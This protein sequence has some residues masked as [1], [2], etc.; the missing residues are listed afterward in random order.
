MAI[1]DAVA[2]QF[3]R[4]WEIF[5]AAVG[6]FPAEE[7]RVGDDDYRV[8]A[9]LAYHLIEAAEFYARARPEGGESLWRGLPDWEAA[10][11]H[12]FPTQPQIV[13]YVDQVQPFVEGWL[14]KA[15]DDDML[16]DNAFPWTE[17]TVL[18]RA[19]YLLRHTQHHVAEL[20]LE[21]RRRGLSRAEWR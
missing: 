8:P 15:G 20:N 14:R 1:G 6:N 12:E 4:A 10:R 5:R 13:A 18:E 21:L 2:N 11:P 9:R 16:A 17:S 19:L 7:W 3:T